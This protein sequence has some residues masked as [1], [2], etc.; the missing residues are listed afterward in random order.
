[1]KS[2]LWWTTFAFVTGSSLAQAASKKNGFMRGPAVTSKR[3]SSAERVLPFLRSIATKLEI[4]LAMLNAGYTDEEQRVGR[5]LLLAATGYSQGPAPATADAKARAA[6]AELDHADESVFRRIHAALGR[7][8]PEQDMFVFA[9]IG[10]GQGA[11]AV[12]SVSKLLE[13]LNALDNSAERADT[14]EA[15]HEALATLAQRGIDAAAL[16]KLR[17]LVAIAQMAQPIETLDV[18]AKDS[19]SREQAL[20]DLLVWYKDWS[21]TARAV[22]QR[23]DYRIIMGLSERRRREE[24]EPPSSQPEPAPAA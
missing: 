16:K 1:M 21:E 4:R 15:D 3:G 24:P 12:V 5:K 2:K 22:I 19:E 7:L 11:A 14:R 18:T 8:Y 23:R 6:I 13:R 9:G 17:E 20:R 10:P